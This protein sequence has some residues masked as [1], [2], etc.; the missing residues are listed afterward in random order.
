MRC[1]TKKKTFFSGGIPLVRLEDRYAVTTPGGAP[2]AFVSF[3]D[4]AE[5]LR[6]GEATNQDH[7]EGC[8]K[9]ET[10]R[11]TFP[12]N[13]IGPMVHSCDY[14]RGKNL[15]IWLIPQ[16]AFS[17][18][19]LIL[20][21][22]FWRR[23]ETTVEYT[24]PTQYL[25]TAKDEDSSEIHVLLILSQKSS[26]TAHSEVRLPVRGTGPTLFRPWRKRHYEPVNVTWTALYLNSYGQPKS[27][28]NPLD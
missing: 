22:E 1:M 10:C 20:T 23:D 8:R 25:A 28:P 16:T 21:P 13:G 11:C 4:F 9:D 6:T 15:E 27:E 2:I 5:M 18:S 17:S 26:I 7:E 24:A 3:E 14:K 19:I 12:C